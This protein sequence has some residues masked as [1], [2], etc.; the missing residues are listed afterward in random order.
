M[1]ELVRFIKGVVITLVLVLGFASCTKD[2]FNKQAPITLTLLME[3][4]LDGEPLEFN[5]LKFPCIEKY[6]ISVTKLEY[7][8]SDV[9]LISTSGKKIHLAEYIYV[10]AKFPSKFNF[11]LNNLEAVSSIEFTFGLVPAIN[12]HDL[13]S[14]TYEHLQMIWPEQLGGGYHFMK[15]EGHYRLPDNTLSG[16]A[17]HLGENGYQFK[18][19]LNPV[20][21]LN[22]QDRVFV[23]NMNLNEWFNSPQLYDF[24]IDGNYSMA[25]EENMKKLTANGVNVFTLKE[26]FDEN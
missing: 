2:S 15:F 20:F 10:D 26:Y 3:H 13:I 17:M 21:Q 9:Y 1:R 16:Y 4:H 11:E 23:L 18:V 19:K 5:T 7:F 25:V 6:V 14:N 24:E 12:E 22:N 8:I